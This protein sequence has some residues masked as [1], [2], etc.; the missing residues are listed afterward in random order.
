MIIKGSDYKLVSISDY[1]W[2][3]Y[4]AKNENSYLSPQYGLP[5]DEAIDRIARYR[6]AKKKEECSIKKYLETYRKFLKE[7]DKYV[8]KEAK[9][10]KIQNSK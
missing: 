4:L 8:H 2:D 5:L 10:N 7:I 9:T 1:F 6:T 3:L